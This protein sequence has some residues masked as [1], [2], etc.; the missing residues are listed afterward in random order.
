MAVGEGFDVE[1][2]WVSAQERA[3]AERIAEAS[4]ATLWD[5]MSLD[6]VMGTLAGCTLAIGVD[7]GL[8]H[9]SGAL[10]VPTVV[11]YGSTD[12]VLTGCRGPW[13]RNLQAD[14]SCS[15]CKRRQCEY[16]GALPIWQDS[17]ISPACYHSVPPEHVWRTAKSL[18]EEV[19]RA[20]RLVSF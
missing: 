14:F 6:E 4:G 9:L 5:A 19:G 2:P 17:S 12:S 15:P 16:R 13:V 18:V 20:D 7:S 1:L 11:V 8:A 3:R 10:K